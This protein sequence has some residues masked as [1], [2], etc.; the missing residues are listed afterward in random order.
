[1][2]DADM[3]WR[4]ANEPMVR[5]NAFNTAPIP[6]AAHLRWLV[7][8][9]C[10]SA[11]RIWIFSDRGR[12]VGQVRIDLA[13]PTAEIDISVAP[14]HRGRGYGRAMLAEAVR[15]TRS[16]WGAD[17]RLRALVL[18]RNPASLALFRSC[19]FRA[20]GRLERS[21]GRGAVVLERA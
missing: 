18:D 1:M 6:Y 21:T 11:T 13:G 7:K 12:A 16:E 8:R 17:L 15:L 10:S 3:L 2:E 5:A 9:L 4:W 20:V 19:G 14:E